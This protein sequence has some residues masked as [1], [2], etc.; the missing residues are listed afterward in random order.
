MNKTPKQIVKDAL[1]N[2][3]WQTVVI[4]LLAGL[5]VFLVL[6]PVLGADTTPVTD[7]KTVKIVPAQGET[8]F[9]VETFCRDPLTKVTVTPNPDA[10]GITY[11][12]VRV[13]DSITE[14]VVYT[15]GP[16]DANRAATHYKDVAGTQESEPA[17][18]NDK[19]RDCLED[20][21]K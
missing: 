8:G 3:G 1:D 9:P 11:Q 19:A 14:S 4:V 7:D 20:K 5:V 6:L 18:V 12:L 15:T 13:K 16:D 10:S 2:G 21:A 17:F